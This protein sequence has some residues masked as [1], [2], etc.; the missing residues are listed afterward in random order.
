[1]SVGVG[2]A[3]EPMDLADHQVSRPQRLPGRDPQGA[4]DGTQVRG[5]PPARMSLSCTPP[6]RTTL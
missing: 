3:F 1:M 6:N 4:V 5:E 2:D